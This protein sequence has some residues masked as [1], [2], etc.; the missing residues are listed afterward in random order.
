MKSGDSLLGITDL[1]QLRNLHLDP[2][3]GRRKVGLS[4]KPE[5]IDKAIARAVELRSRLESISVVTVRD[6]DEKAQLNTEAD[7]ALETLRKVGD[8]VVGCAL[9]AELPG[10]ASSEDQMA[11][12]AP[13]VAAALDADQPAELREA[14]LVQIE[15]RGQQ[16]LDAGRPDSA[17]SRHPFHWP[18]AF[19]ESFVDQERPGFDA[20]VGNPPFKRG[21]GI[22]GVFGVDYRE[23]LV[24]VVAQGQRASADLVAYFFRRCSTVSNGF[25]LLAINS[26]PQADSRVIGLE[27]LLN[28]GWTIQ[29]AE[30]DFPWPGGGPTVCKVWASKQWAGPRSLNGMRTAGITNAL[31]PAGARSSEPRILAENDDRA[32][33]GV[34]VLG[35]GFL[36]LPDEAAALISSDS[37]NGEV[38]FPFLNGEDV[39]RSPRHEA[40]DGR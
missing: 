1:D 17:P 28:D 22:T 37:R 4:L 19:P 2:A 14:A 39:N 36:L 33:Q 7:E 31:N 32:F 10:Q 40:P 34:V 30:T 38:L 26:L 20:M 16:A 8:L 12:F 3:V 13:L 27:P 11:A 35:E 5:A 9:R 6:A 23:H 18:L 29:R 24:R 25:G 15:A 21:K